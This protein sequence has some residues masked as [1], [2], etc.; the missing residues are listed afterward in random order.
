MSLDKLTLL[1]EETALLKAYVEICDVMD[2]QLEEIRRK[3]KELD[4][5]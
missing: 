3:I 5:G 1:A 2:K 4:N